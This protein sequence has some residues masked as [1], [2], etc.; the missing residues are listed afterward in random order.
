ML[1]MAYIFTVDLSCTRILYPQAQTV[2][3]RLSAGCC[4]H[5]H[6]TLTRYPYTRHYHCVAVRSLAD[7]Q[8]VLSDEQCTVTCV[9]RFLIASCFARL[10]FDADG[11]LEFESCPTPTRKKSHIFRRIGPNKLV[12]CHSLMLPSSDEGVAALRTQI[13]LSNACVVQSVP[14]S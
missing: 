5:L 10:K 1:A 12:C 8:H 13:H 11:N 9:E 14:M 2:S 4:A 7:N 6:V 3:K